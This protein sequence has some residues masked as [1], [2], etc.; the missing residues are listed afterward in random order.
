M[1]KSGKRKQMETFADTSA[2]NAGV[3]EKNTK[4]NQITISK[5]QKCI[6]TLVTYKD[7]SFDGKYA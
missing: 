1:A 4:T 2:F 5:N 7:F 3:K 6:F